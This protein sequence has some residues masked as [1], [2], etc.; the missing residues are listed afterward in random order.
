[1]VD[2]RVQEHLVAVVGA[3]AA[4]A[5]AGALVGVRGVIGSTNVALLMVL[6]VVG[7]AASG[8]RLA[9]G[10]TGIA[11]A[12]SYNFFHTVPYRSLRITD[13]RD[14]ITVIL[15]AVVGAVVGEV[16]QRWERSRW[17]ATRSRLGLDRVTK[18]AELAVGGAAIDDVIHE[19]ER[20]I[21]TELRL[22]EVRFELGGLAGEERPVLSHTGVVQEPS[23]VFVDGEFAF[24][25]A[26]VDLDVTYHGHTFGRLVLLPQRTT[27][28]SL[29][30]RRCAVALTDQL[31]AAL[32]ADASAS[33]N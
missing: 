10:V 16:A 5:L 23:R 17:D 15:L 3:I 8:G 19:V 33:A 27:G 12:V 14:V 1:M 30:Q 32:A 25:H 31:G 4:I 22:R 28:V 13:H 2:A 26:G 21:R 11:A 29:P 24:P 18:V 6:L 7:A 20:E 9:G